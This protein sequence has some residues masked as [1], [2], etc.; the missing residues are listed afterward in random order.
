M[1]YT[2]ECIL[3]DMIWEV[4][5]ELE[6]PGSYLKQIQ[7]EDMG[8]YLNNLEEQQVREEDPEFWKNLS[9]EDAQKLIFE[10]LQEKNSGRI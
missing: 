10:Y 1:I 7:I 6:T 4:E 8:Q 3:W 5:D 2:A 9:E